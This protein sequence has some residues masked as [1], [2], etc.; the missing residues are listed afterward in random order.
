[1]GWGAG[2]LVG[3]VECRVDVGQEGKLCRDSWAP[4]FYEGYSRCA[5]GPPDARFCRES[6]LHKE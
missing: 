6:S 4:N 5:L 2:V 3:W 1:M